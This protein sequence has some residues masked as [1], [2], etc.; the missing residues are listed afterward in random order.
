MRII[1]PVLIDPNSRRWNNRHSTHTCARIQAIFI[2][3]DD[4]IVFES[5]ERDVYVLNACVRL[6][7]ET[8]IE[9][10]TTAIVIEHIKRDIN[11]HIPYEVVGNAQVTGRDQESAFRVSRES[12]I[13]YDTDHILYRG[14]FHSVESIRLE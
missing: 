5:I 14:D 8:N 2:R 9:G 12:V 1:K 11:R 10:V 6:W 13:R 7:I 3:I 4:S